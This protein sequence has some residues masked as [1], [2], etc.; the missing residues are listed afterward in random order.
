MAV[1]GI[2]LGTTNSL[3]AA[4]TEAGPRLI[5][6]GLGEVLTPSAVSI[7]DGEV[8]VGRA[9]LE[10]LITHPDRSAAAFKRFMGTNRQ[11]VLAGRAYR[12]EE[13]SALVLGHLKRAAEAELGE[14]IEDAV[15]S[16][17]AY[18]ND[19]QRKA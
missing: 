19:L 2:D 18:F 17:P 8:L 16:V 10:R 1:V 9:A 13:L 14:P 7:D 6:N 15:I 3:I 12:P 5:A 4:W 11:T